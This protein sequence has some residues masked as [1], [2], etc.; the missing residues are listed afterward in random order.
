MNFLPR[1]KLSLINQVKGFCDTDGKIQTT[2]CNDNKVMITK[3][4]SLSTSKTYIRD[5]HTPLAICRIQPS[6]KIR[7]LSEFIKNVQILSIF[8]KYL[9]ILQDF[10]SN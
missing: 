9:A 3:G 10:D 4:V 2:V 8:T 5:F 7:A 6:S 1:P